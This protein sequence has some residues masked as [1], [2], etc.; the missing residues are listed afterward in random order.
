M[1]KHRLKQKRRGRRK[2]GL[3]KRILGTPEQPRLTVYRSLKHT[4]A[5]VIDDLQGRTIASA[6]TVQAGHEYGG[7]V[8]AAAQV[9]KQLAERAS[10]AGVQQ[11]TFDRNG[12]KY[13]GRVRALADAAREGGLKF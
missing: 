5:Q 10:A 11:V 7:N 4:Y 8:D 12:F 6:N 13:H 2:A 3:R 9:G 1:D